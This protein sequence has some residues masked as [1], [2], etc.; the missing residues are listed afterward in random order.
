MAK[1]APKPKAAPKSREP[2][3]DPAFEPDPPAAPPAVDKA[4]TITGITPIGDS[5][6]QLHLS[7]GDTIECICAGNGGLEANREARARLLQKLHPDKE[8]H[9][10]E[11]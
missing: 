2:T 6:F 10:P 3:P 11:R 4:V 9:G 8:S 5:S 1:T 7:D